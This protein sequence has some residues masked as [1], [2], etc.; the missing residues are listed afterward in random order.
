L[1]SHIGDAPHYDCLRDLWETHPEAFMARDAEEA[2]L[3]A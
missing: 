1:H 2:L 3:L